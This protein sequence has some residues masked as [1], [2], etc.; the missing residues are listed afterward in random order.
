MEEEGKLEV[1]DLH[2]KTEGSPATGGGARGSCA[3]S[4]VALKLGFRGQN[5]EGGEGYL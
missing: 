5:E 1:V 3:S 4:L 2:R